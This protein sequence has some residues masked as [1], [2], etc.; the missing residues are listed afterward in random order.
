MAVPLSPLSKREVPKT[1]YYDMVPLWLYM[2]PSLIE[3]E[4]SVHLAM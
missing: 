3:G 4:P 2:H 1:P